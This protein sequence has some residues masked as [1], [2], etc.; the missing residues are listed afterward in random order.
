MKIAHIGSRGI[1][2]RYSGVEKIVEETS[3]RLVKQGFKVSVYC[4]SDNFGTSRYEGIR[5][6]RIPTINTKHL[7]TLIHSFLS[8]LHVIFTDTQVVHYHCLGP[9]VFSFIPR[10]LG[11]KTIVTIHAL[12][13]KRAKW[14]HLAKFALKLCEIPAIYF[15]NKTIV[16]SLYL[17]NY[18]KRKYNKE[19]I[20]IPNGISVPPH[21]RASSLQPNSSYILFVGRIVPEKGLHYLIKA[22]N[23]IHTDKQLWIAGAPSFTNNYLDQLKKN[24]WKQC[25]ISWA[26]AWRKIDRI[27]QKCLHTHPSF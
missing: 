25:E 11:K 10:I 20:Y 23:E 4:H 18:F 27:I 19:I 3:K 2:A 12:D 14:N 7:A 15:P 21:R 1:P 22:F 9:S 5:L 6:I 8:T 17:K 13:W 24:G 16:V 26:S